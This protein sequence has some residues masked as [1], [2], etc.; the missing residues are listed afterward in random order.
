MQTPHLFCDECGAANTHQALTCC[1]CGRPLLLVQPDPIPPTTTAEPAPAAPLYLQFT[2]SPGKPVQVRLIRQERPIRRVQLLHDRYEIVDRVGSG[3]FGAVYKARDTGHKNRLVAIKA[4]KLDM[5]SV[6]QAIE[7]TDTF[8]RELHLLSR[9]DHAHLP[10]IYEHFIDA[11][12]WYLVMDFIDGEP[13]D[14]YLKQIQEPDLP[15]REVI[16]IGLQLCD[17]L[18]Y[19]HSRQPPVIF[20]DVKP[21][22][23]IR[24]PGGRIYLIDFGIARRFKPGQKRDTTPLG[25]PGFAA[26]EQYGNAQTTARTDIYG[27]GATLYF[28]LTG[29]DPATTPFHLPSIL[30]LRPAL[31]HTLAALINSMLAADP[32]E[33]PP[34]MATIQQ[35]LFQSMSVAESRTA[36]S[37][38]IRSARLRAY[39]VGQKRVPAPPRPA[40][41]Q[42]PARPRGWF[43]RKLFGA[44]LP[45]AA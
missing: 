42:K 18:G 45:L 41:G 8:N 7:A 19:L 14:T 16:D 2:L 20:R 36:R 44:C 35:D 9:L 6:S 43:W 38:Q 33:R 24:T 28:L 37:L 31:P 3:G 27:L 21:A 1:A 13:L 23:I 29:Y 39:G 22:N 5:L 30:S 12:H 32:Q 17:V 11:T 10:A 4:I 26:P 15:I 40:A 25:S 34:D